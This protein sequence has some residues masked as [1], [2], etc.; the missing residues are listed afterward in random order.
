MTP[1]FVLRTLVVIFLISSA[2][3][4]AC[5]DSPGEEFLPPYQE[6][7]STDGGMYIPRRPENSSGYGSGY[8]SGASSYASGASE[9]SDSKKSS[10]PKKNAD[11][12]L[13]LDQ[14]VA[15]EDDSESV[16]AIIE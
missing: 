7:Y 4:S 14:G 8:G 3:F 16:D 11:H 12:K 1:P 2:V 6:E 5:I 9:K 15:D 10:D 13:E